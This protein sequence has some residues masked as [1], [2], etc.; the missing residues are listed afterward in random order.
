LHS[1]SIIHLSAADKGIN[2][3]SPYRRSV[4]NADSFPW[5][6]LLGRNGETKN[7]RTVHWHSISASDT[8]IEFSGKAP[9]DL[10]LESVP[11]FPG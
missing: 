10:V 2:P 11:G 7:N 8:K 9:P 5:P 4:K 6:V 1:I 3:F